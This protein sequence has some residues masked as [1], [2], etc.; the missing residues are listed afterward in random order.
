MS[1]IFWVFDEA[2]A[3]IKVGVREEEDV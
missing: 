3:D 1:G 2:N